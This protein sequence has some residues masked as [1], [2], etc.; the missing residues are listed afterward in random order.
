MKDRIQWN[1]WLSRREAGK[2]LSVSPD[3]VE[4]RGV[5]WQD[6]PVPH[7]VRY[8]FLVLDEDAEPERRYYEPDVEA[9]IFRREHLPPAARLRL[10]ATFL[11]P[12]VPRS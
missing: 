7:R 2:K 9:L 4:R 8:R 12:A 3:T 1:V 11:P 6:E 10:T 5:E